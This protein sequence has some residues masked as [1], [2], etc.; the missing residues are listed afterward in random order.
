MLEVVRHFASSTAPRR[1]CAPS[2]IFSPPVAVQ[3]CHVKENVCDIVARRINRQLVVRM[4]PH[5]DGERRNVR[6]SVR[7]GPTG[8]SDL[9]RAVLG[10]RNTSGD[11]RLI[12]LLAAAEQ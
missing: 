4:P 11:V 12:L 6:P 1:R 5:T 10:V 7:K 3:F 2:F 8:V 9:R